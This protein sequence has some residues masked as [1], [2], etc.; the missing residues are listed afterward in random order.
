MQPLEEKVM[1]E[2]DRTVRESTSVN[3]IYKFGST[4]P[5]GTVESMNSVK[6]SY[7]AEMDELEQKLV[8]VDEN[9]M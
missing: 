6:K 9:V 4:K 8:A 5:V 1:F 7:H 2:K 3:N